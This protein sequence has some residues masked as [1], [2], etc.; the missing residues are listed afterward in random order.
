MITSAAAPASQ[1]YVWRF[2]NGKL[3]TDTKMPKAASKAIQSALATIESMS[4]P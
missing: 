2:V 1:A 4:S 3:T